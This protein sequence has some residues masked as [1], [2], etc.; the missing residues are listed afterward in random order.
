[1]PHTTITL[2]EG[3][4]HNPAEPR[5]FMSVDP[6]KGRVRILLNDQL[7]A[8]T[9]GA[10]RLKEVGLQLYDPVI[11]VSPDDVMAPLT[12]TD[13]TTHCPLKGDC[14]WFSLPDAENVAW[15]YEKP[16]AFAEVIAGRVAFDT[17][18]VAIEERP[19]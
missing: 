16:F 18:Q 9:Q 1:M 17:T 2:A 5:H 13:R 11:Y 4:I 6:I 19:E 8:D 3:T 7:I 12:E 15:S 14:T 10:L